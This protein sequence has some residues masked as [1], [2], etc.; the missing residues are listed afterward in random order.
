MVPVPAA[1]KAEIGEGGSG[2]TDY[3]YHEGICRTI[4]KCTVLCYIL[5]RI[6]FG[7][8]T[9]QKFIAKRYGTTAGNLHNWL[10]KRGIKRAK[11]SHNRL[12]RFTSLCFIRP[13]IPILLDV[14]RRSEPDTAGR[15]SP[16]GDH[17]VRGWHPGRAAR[18]DLVED[19]EEIADDALGACVGGG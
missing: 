7:F 10:K 19:P 14:A 8:I 5:V 4:R 2:K 11:G 6:F 9:F 13:E 15:G 1:V 17:E 18:V 12:W 3:R 16:R